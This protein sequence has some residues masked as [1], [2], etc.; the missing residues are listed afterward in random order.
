MK[1]IAGWTL[2]LI[3]ISIMLIYLSGSIGSSVENR[4]NTDNSTINENINVDAENEK[5]VITQRQAINDHWEEIKE[6]INGTGT[7]KA[8]YDFDNHCYFLKVDL[9][10]GQITYMYFPN[11]GYLRFDVVELDREGL[12]EATSDDDRDWSFDLD[13]D[14]DAVYGAIT[15]W[16]DNANFTITYDS[17]DPEVVARMKSQVNEYEK[18][19]GRSIE[20][21]ALLADIE[22]LYQGPLDYEK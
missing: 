4:T 19:Y 2:A 18:K 9:K 15:E 8:C 1:K 11:G 10:S 20:Y 7:V 3:G 6:Y 17:P 21:F 12:G 22:N 13:L 5:T 16:A 14:N